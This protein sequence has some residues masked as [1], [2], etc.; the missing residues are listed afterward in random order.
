MV[1]S[2]LDLRWYP[3]NGACDWCACDA[4]EKG[5]HAVSGK[6]ADRASPAVSTQVCPVD[7]APGYHSG[8]VS[9]ARL[10][11]ARRRSGSGGYLVYPS[12]SLL[13]A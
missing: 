1:G 3:S 2:D 13:S 9:A 4:V 5:D 8:A 11:D 7:L 6:D 10:S 12:I